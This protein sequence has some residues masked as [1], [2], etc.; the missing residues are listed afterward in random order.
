MI[1]LSTDTDSLEFVPGNV[2][3][4]LFTCEPTTNSGYGIIK[5]VVF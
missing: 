5:S 2:F 1:L 4:I 3:T